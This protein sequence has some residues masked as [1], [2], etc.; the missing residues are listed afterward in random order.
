MIQ[1]KRH[2][3][4]LEYGIDYFDLCP[5]HLARFSRGWS[6]FFVHALPIFPW[7]LYCSILPVY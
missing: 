7:S 1:E 3:Q 2:A 4:G 5:L 6:D